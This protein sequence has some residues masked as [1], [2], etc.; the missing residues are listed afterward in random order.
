[1]TERLVAALGGL[2]IGPA[3]ALAVVFACSVRW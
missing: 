2:L 3:I 1:M